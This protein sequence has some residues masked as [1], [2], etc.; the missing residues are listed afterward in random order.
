MGEDSAR[1]GGRETEELKEKVVKWRVGDDKIC[2][3]IRV[4]FFFFV[5]RLNIEFCKGMG[6]F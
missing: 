6:E 1:E 3:R 4:F 5:G 2:R